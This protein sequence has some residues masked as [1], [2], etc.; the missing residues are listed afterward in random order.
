MVGFFFGTSAVYRHTTNW[1]ITIETTKVVTG[2]PRHDLSNPHYG[3]YEYII[4]KN[5]IFYCSWGI[6]MISISEKNKMKKV[7][8]ENFPSVTTNCLQF[9]LRRRGCLGPEDQERWGQ[10]P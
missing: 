4:M 7:T 8:S 9:G 1:I 3:I 10:T 5:G 2:G 6:H